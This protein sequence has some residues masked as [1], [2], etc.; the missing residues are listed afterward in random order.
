MKNNT[1]K[2]VNELHQQL[3]KVEQEIHTV[4]EKLQSQQRV[5]PMEYS[6]N[7]TVVSQ[8]STNKISKL[9]RE[10]ELIKNAVQVIT[11]VTAFGGYSCWDIGLAA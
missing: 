5:N 3:D 4:S 1:L 10:V 2:K 9:F 11:K 6:T 8:P 7:E